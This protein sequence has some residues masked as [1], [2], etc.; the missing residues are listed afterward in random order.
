MKINNR[1]FTL[2]ELLVVMAIIV[3]MCGVSL[4]YLSTFSPSTK[5][6]GEANQIFNQIHKT[7]NYALTE[8]E[9][10]SIKFTK[11]TGNYSINKIANENSN[12]VESFDLQNGIVFVNNDLEIRFNAAGIPS[13]S[14]DI[15]I[16]NQKGE[17]STIQVTTTGYVKI[18]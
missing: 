2:N 5:L 8:Q 15:T 4:I 13:S 10:Y 7:Q 16:Q 11:T 1:G 6:K 3:I 17:S 18:I 9:I 12:L 14:A